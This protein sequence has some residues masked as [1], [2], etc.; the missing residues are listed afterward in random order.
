LSIR[1][2]RW[3][4]AHQPC[5]RL[6]LTALA[7]A[8]ALAA[9]LVSARPAHAALSAVGPVNPATNFPDWY[10]D[11]T[12]LKLQLCVDGPPF[13]LAAAAEL[14]PPEGEAFWS[15]AEAVVPVGGGEARLILAQEAAFLE[16]DPISFSRI[17]V[18]VRGAAPNR[19]YA[20]NHPYGNASVTTDGLGNGR[21]NSDVGCGAGPCD[22]AA[23]LRGGIGPEFLRWDPTV[24][25]APPAGYIGDSITPHAVVGG[26]VRNS[27]GVSGGA[28]TRLFTVQGKLAGPPVPV[29]SASSTMDFGPAN[30][31]GPVTR[32]YRIT[33]F[34]VPDAGGASNLMFGPITPA[35]APDFTIVGNT[36]SGRVLPSGTNCDLTL[37]FNP[38]ALGPRNATLDIV[39]NG[40]NHGTRVVLGG[41][42]IPTAVVAAASA[43][44]PLRITRL[45]TT[46]RMSRA[47]VLRRGL[48]FSMRLPQGTEILKI[49]VYRTRSG[50]VIRKPVWLGF[51]V[52]G[53]IPPSG[54]YRI[55]LDSR[56]LRQR[57]KAGL[58][59][60]NITPGL[61]KRDLGRTSTTRI[62]ITRRGPR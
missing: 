33:S 34:G 35:G 24:A 45:R 51:R 37:Q 26:S 11:G 58:Y 30:L 46:H 14:I 16:A 62:R 55:R 5:L 10:Q 61:S 23:A 36:C 21:F 17:R 32:S 6:G 49:A 2:S 44:S 54:L 1:S 15:Q 18:V 60:V 20:F 27:F 57:L 47:R 52:V 25:P 3:A 40:Q 9:G 12:G 31:G 39:H 4:F 41:T 8:L 22:W 7:A 53:R 19:T 29:F 43:R 28:S 50:K 56:A 59:Q 42:G 13:C 48:R 38:G